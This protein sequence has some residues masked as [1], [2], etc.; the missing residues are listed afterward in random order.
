[1]E[2]IEARLDRVRLRFSD[3]AFLKNE[4]L[5]NEVGLYIFAYRPQEEMAVR[6]FIE[7]ISRE[8]GGEQTACRVRAYDLYEFL[9][10][11]CRERRILERIAPWRRSAGRRS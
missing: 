7:R 2:S 3:R 10:D 5:S 4:G 6:V 1:M 8:Y 11:I 9:L